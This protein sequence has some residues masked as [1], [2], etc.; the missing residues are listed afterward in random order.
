MDLWNEKDI[1]YKVKRDKYRIYANAMTHLSY[2]KID[3]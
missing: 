2:I 3:Y 1:F